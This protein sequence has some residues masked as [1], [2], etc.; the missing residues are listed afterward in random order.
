MC[1][2]GRARS[3]KHGFDRVL[4]SPHAGSAFEEAQVT[5]RPRFFIIAVLLTFL[6]LAVGCLLRLAGLDNMVR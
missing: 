1:S 4:R 2:H 5:K 6:D 3:S